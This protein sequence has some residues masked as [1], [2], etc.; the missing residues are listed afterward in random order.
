MTVPAIPPGRVMVIL[1][2]FAVVLGGLVAAVS[3]PLTLD[4]GSWVAAYL[5]LVCGAAQY[6]IG[7]MQTRPG[8]RQPSTAGSWTQL[9]CWNLGNL[10]VLAGTLTDTLRVLD[11]GAMLLLVTLGIAMMSWR[12]GTSAAAERRG[13]S[14]PEA[15]AALVEWGYRGLVLCL[16]ISVPI[17]VV[18][19]HLRSAAG[20]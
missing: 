9:I 14:G 13:R 8:P 19:A 12:R 4:R 7:T 11:A 15:G 5:V 17:G 10:A 18:L 1:G 2:G 6:T 20:G 16:A 3:T